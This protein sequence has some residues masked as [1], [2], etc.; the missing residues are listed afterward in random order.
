[1][2]KDVFFLDLQEIASFQVEE[3]KKTLG[4]KSHIFVFYHK[5]DKIGEEILPNPEIIRNALEMIQN[6]IQKLLEI[7]IE[8]MY[9]IPDHG[10]LIYPENYS[11]QIT[12][13]S[14]N[15]TNV[16]RHRRYAIGKSEDLEENPAAI[17]LNLGEYGFQT[18]LIGLFPIG[19]HK[20]AIHGEEHR[21]DHGGLSLQENALILLEL[22]ISKQKKQMSIKLEV[23]IPDSITT[24][25][26]IVNLKPIAP[27]ISNSPR[28]VIVEAFEWNSQQDQESDQIDLTLIGKSEVIKVHYSQVNAKLLLQSLPKAVHI[29]VMD[30]KTFEILDEKVVQVLLEGY[31]DLL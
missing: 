28:R 13:I 5:L 27:D 3:L 17:Q 14:A 23:G 20:F 2:E 26:I 6:S 1:M 21:F 30:N 16:I 29:K 25:Q 31:D 4:D 15:S 18:D 12:P 10:F 11:P 9:F 24:A 8:K 19:I 22:E 7:G